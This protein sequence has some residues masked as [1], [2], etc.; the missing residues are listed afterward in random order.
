MNSWRLKVIVCLFFVLAAIIIG[1]LFYIQVL[2]HKYYQSQALGQQ[3][4]FKKIQG[5]R[6]EVFFKNS[7]ESHGNI[8]S[9]ETKSLAI[10]KEKWLV[11]TVPDNIKDKDAFAGIVSSYTGLSRE[12]ILAK[13][14]E[15]DSY[16]VLKKDLAPEDVKKLKEASIQGLVFENSVARYYPQEELASQVIGFLGGGNAGQYGIE[17]YYED[18]LEG[19]EGIQEQ[20]SGLGIINSG[21]NEES[22]NG[23]DLFLTIDYNIQFQA[24]ALLREAKNNIDIDSG[25]IIVVKPDSGRILA[26][27]N[28][29][30]FNPNRYSKETNFDIFQNATVQKIFE[31]GSVFK[32]FI[33][34]MAFNEGKVSPDST[35]IDEGFVKI[36]PDTLYNFNKKVYGQ[37][38]MSGIL[39]NSI[40]T[41]AVYLSSLIS[42]DT[43]LDYLDKFGFNKKTEIDLQGEVY[44]RNEYLKNG[45]NFG[46][47]TASFGQGIEM[48]PLQLIRAFSLFANGGKIVKPYIV[49]KITRGQ[50]EQDIQPQVSDS[51]LSQQTISEVTKMMINV[52]DKGFGKSAGIKGYYLAGKTGTAEVPI[53]NGKGYYT[54]KTIQSFIGFGPAL[55]P[56]FLILVK[57][58]NP[59]I[60]K[61][62]L[63]AA[64]IFK[65]L[66]QYIINYWQIPPDY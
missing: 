8:G 24:E 22:L 5:D 15:S 39:E 66:A 61:S 50:D 47:A 20:K 14:K 40:N 2:N 41:G 19:K 28:F 18:I 33:M 63:S 26:L 58:D 62:S 38:N 59:K 21:S 56:Q 11:A 52:V 32:P 29:P 60:P 42:H 64:P 51:G 12:F 16:V 10:N 9:G 49:E 57:L 36:G 17:G 34:A 23:S 45:S 4:G 54:D 53:T 37:Q 25:Q 65:K 35:F 48:T 55:K 7:K 43:F 1:R 13:I 44:S 46:F 3:V 31:P 27:A 6:G 30:P